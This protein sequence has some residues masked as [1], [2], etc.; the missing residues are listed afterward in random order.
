[1]R[2]KPQCLET[3]RNGCLTMR[4]YRKPN[5]RTVKTMEMPWSLWLSVRT[6]VM[7]RIPG[8]EKTEASR[9]RIADI[10]ALLRAGEK[11]E[12]IADL[13]GVTGQRVR[14]IKCRMK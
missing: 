9:D 6:G 4:R 10:Q 7:K 12:Y 1:M 13:F 14:Q 3:R 11:S 5:G 2:T 8:Y